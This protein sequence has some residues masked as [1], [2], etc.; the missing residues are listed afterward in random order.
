MTQF[1]APTRFARAHF[2]RAVAGIGLLMLG[3]LP[4]GATTIEKVVSPGGIE[5]WLV[6]DETL[7]M[8][9]MNFAFDGGSAQ[10]PDG[11]E[12]LTNLLA[13]TMDEGAGDLDSEAFQGKLEELAVSI[14]FNAGKDQLFGTLRT[15]TGTRDEA[16]DLLR[17]AVNEPRF[18]EKPVERVKAQILA[19]LRQQQEDPDAIASE[20]FRNAAFGGHPYGKPG[21]GIVETV[22]KLAPADLKTMHGDLLSR[23]KL[24]IGVVG[25]ID[26]KTLA[27]LLDEVFGKLPEKHKLPEVVDVEPK[28]GERISRTLDVPQT[29]ILIGLPGLK[30][31]DPD[32][33]AAFV[34]NHILGGGTFTSW[35]F[36]E[37]REKRGLSYGV[38]S[39]LAP[40][41]HSA[42][43]VASAATRA[44][45]ADET[46]SII[47][48]QF[49]RMAEQGPTQEELDKAKSFLTGSYALRFD[50]SG[51]IAAQLVALKL[52]DLG[53]DYF[54]R[55]NAEIEA[56]TLEDVQRIAKRLLEG[57][58]PLI[59]TVGP[60]A[61]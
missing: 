24:A 38:G 29:T 41:D 43:L 2:T 20:A 27:P 57:K 11:K 28:T 53:I 40:D 16:F 8:I 51:K 44:D 4:A 21:D 45:R 5:A 22:E 37:V 17:L 60:Q 23:H 34:M 50:T 58:T 18:D 46:I 10:D 47:E 6:Q 42:L 13:S 59:V 26:A 52:A 33:Q 56:V 49:K 32:Y 15:L 36:E 54:D 30:R 48:E 55:R 61:S 12:G 9:S 31:D 35:L 14:R 3:A 39:D 1:F 19:G 7:P 25:A